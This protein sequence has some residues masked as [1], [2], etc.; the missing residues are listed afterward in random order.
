MTIND[1][2]T[3]EIGSLRLARR[4]AGLTQEQLAARADCSVDYIRLLERGYVPRFSDVIP[5][6]LDALQGQF[7]PLAVLRREVGL[8][9]GMLAIRAG[10]TKALV[11]RLESGEENPTRDDAD[12]LASALEVSVDRLF[13]HAGRATDGRP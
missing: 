12:A 4:E 11:A 10:M 6:V 3:A 7:S 13:P 9:Q 8:T 2:G 1:D 5:R